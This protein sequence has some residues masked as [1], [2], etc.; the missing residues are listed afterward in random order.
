MLVALA[1]V[2]ALVLAVQLM[3]VYSRYM[4]ASLLEVLNADYVR[5][6]RAK[7]AGERRVVGRHA[8]RNAMI[9]VTTQLAGDVGALFGGLVITE[10]VFQ[11][12]GTGL[13]FI[14]AVDFV[15]I[16]IMATY[17]LLVGVLFVA[18][19]LVVDVLYAVVDPRLRVERVAARA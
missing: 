10:T 6:A 8:M 18:I 1:A 12:P 11:W 14:Q 15:D 17:L 5:T 2:P 4:R 9:P 19:N 7:G 3:A 13:M 16:P